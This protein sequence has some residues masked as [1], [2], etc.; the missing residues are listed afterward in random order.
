[1]W[2]VV[3]VVILAVVTLQAR[4]DLSSYAHSIANLHRLDFGAD[5]DSMANDFVTD[6]DRQWSFTPASVD[7]MY[8]GAADTTAFDLDVDIVVA[9]LLW[10]ELVMSGTSIVELRSVG[11]LLLLE[12]S[13]LLLVI[14]HEPF[15]G[16]WITH[17]CYRVKLRTMEG[18]VC[19]PGRME[20]EI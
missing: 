6:A 13:P 17:G 16:V 14:D 20:A 15:K 2:A 3:L 11:Y 8:V 18:F 7:Q 5:L 4:P 19:G 9:K 1:M 12:V 10:F